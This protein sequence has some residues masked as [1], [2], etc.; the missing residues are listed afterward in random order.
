MPHRTKTGQKTH[1]TEVSKWAKGKE[2]EGFDV[3]AD[4]PGWE[5]PPKIKGVIPDA[6]AKKGLEKKVLEVETPQTLEKDKEQREKL[7]EW[8]DDG[9]DR[10]FFTKVARRK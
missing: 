1:D 3:T 2:K 10:T 7:R 4:L 5:K 8:A 6:L 9:K